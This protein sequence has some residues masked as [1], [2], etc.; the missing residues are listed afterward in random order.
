MQTLT[1]L[2]ILNDSGLIPGGYFMVSLPSEWGEGLAVTILVGSDWQ[3]HGLSL[4]KVDPL[5]LS[6][7]LCR[8]WLYKNPSLLLAKT[9]LSKASPH[10]P[11]VLPTLY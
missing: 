6:P 3:L 10:S 4:F 9:D 11:C 1:T 5:A 7:D 2:Q 8:A